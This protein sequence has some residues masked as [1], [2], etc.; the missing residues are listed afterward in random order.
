MKIVIDAGH[1]GTDPGAVNMRLNLRECDVAL[2]YAQR[3]AQILSDAGHHVVMTRGAD[4][5]VYLADRACISNVWKA[6]LFLSIHCNSAKNWEAAGIEVWTSPGQSESDLCAT[7]LLGAIAQAFPDRRLRADMA[8]GDPDREARFYV[9][10][11]TSAPA[12]LI[13]TGFLSNDEE[14]A[15][16]ADADTAA[17]YAQ[18]IANGVLS[19]AAGRA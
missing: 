8:D 7:E 11:H 18:A 2:E 13:E 19:W 1:G 10:V 3:V 14:A 9:L 16:L 12:V 4:S 5:F 6:D 17:N 15:W